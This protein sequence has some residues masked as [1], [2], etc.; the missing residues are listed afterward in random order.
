MNK[1]MWIIQSLLAHIL[2]VRASEESYY[3]NMMDSWNLLA[4]VPE[5]T[6]NLN[7][8]MQ[9]E[10]V[11]SCSLGLQEVFQI[12]VWFRHICPAE[13]SQAAHSIRKL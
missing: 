9:T 5:S 13:W 8:T 3:W 11:S 7:S 1:L 4:V 12:F 6:L 10:K 2:A